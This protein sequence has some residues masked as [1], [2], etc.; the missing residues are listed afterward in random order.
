MS[1]LKAFIATVLLAVTTAASGQSPLKFNENGEFKILQFTDTHFRWNKGDEKTVTPMMVEAIEAEKPDF[2]IITGD[3]VYSNNVA[4]IL[5]QLFQPIVDSGIPFAFVFGNHDHQFELNRS[6]IYDIIQA[7]PGCIVP[8]RGDAQSPDYVLEVMSSDGSKP[9][10][11]LYCLDSH[12]GAQVNGAGR[13]AWLTTNQV[14][15]YKTN[16]IK[17]TEANDN[18]PLPSLMFFHIPLP[19][20]KYALDDNSIYYVGQA[21]EKVCSPHMNSGMFTAIKEQNDVFAT[22]FGH[23]HDNDFL[24][25]YYDVLLGYGRY[26][27]SKGAVYNHLGKNGA[28]VIVLKEGKKELDTWLRLRGEEQTVDKVNYPNDFKGKKRKSKK[29]KKNQQEQPET[30]E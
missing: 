15:W 5:P 21:R 20:T 14:V 23:D 1:K 29:D 9:A 12:A 22:F 30:E 18:N 11:V 7:M 2:I 24:I 6:Q 19:E 4:K 3:L 28:R 25:P 13:Y 26:G 16:S 27:G 8:K 17:Y 10:A